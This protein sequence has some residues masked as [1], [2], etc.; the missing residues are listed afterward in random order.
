MSFIRRIT[1]LITRG[2]ERSVR[3]K[4]NVLLTIVLKGFGV[5]IGFLYFPLSL[6]YLGAVKFG[7]FLTL[8]SIVDWFLNFDIGISRGLRNKFGEAVAEQDDFKAVHYVS[9][10]YFSLGA[11]IL[12]VTVILIILNFLLPWPGWLN[13]DPGLVREVRLLGLIIIIAFGIRFVA[14]II[15]EIFY[16]LQQMAYVEFFTLI[17]KASFLVLILIIP[18]IVSDSLLLFGAAKSL[19]FALV[20]LLAGIY[21]FH[22]KFNRYRPKLRFAKKGYFK[23]LFS[24]GFKFFLIKIAM[25]IIHQTNNILIAGFVSLEGVSQY[26]AA[27]KYLSIFMMLFVILN[28]QL[29]P[30]NLEAYVKGELDWMKKALRTVTYIWLG[31]V[32]LAS[33]MVLISPWFYAF[34][35][36]DNLQVPLLISIAVAVSICLTTF[37]NM[38]NMVLNGTGKITLQMIAWVVAAVI[39]I[40]ASIFFVNVLHMGVEGIVLGTIISLIPLAVLSPIQVRKILKRK[41][42]GIWAK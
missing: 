12:L 15:Y 18:F 2:S 8:L 11:I 21:Y 34:W 9:T 25:L 37:V 5:L 17:T 35:L 1:Q 38:F 28:N 14:A 19:T 10:A 6:D 36:Q 26:E 22:R 27:Y 29:W 40:P 31:T 23:D 24:L 33:L 7:I 3:A 16:A 4:K 42:T 30:S 39:N 20:P 13:I 32:V 41:E